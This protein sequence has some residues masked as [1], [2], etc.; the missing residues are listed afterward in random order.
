MKRLRPDYYDRFTCIAGACPITCCQEWKINVDDATARRWKKL[1]PP[2]D[3]EEQ[4]PNLYAYTT[5]K[6]GERVIGLTPDH[7]CPFLNEDK[8]C[9][10]VC[11]HGDQILSRTCQNF[12]REV[13]RFRTHE[14]E[15]LM[16]ACP[17]V[18]DILNE[19][20]TL[21]F[22][23]PLP[24]ELPSEKARLLFRLRAE[25]IRLLTDEARR[26]SSPEEALLSLAY[27]L[28]ELHRTG[29]PDETR[30]TEYFSAASREQLSKALADI[31]LPPLDTL[32]ECNE[33]LQDLAVNYQK[34]GLYPGY[35][36]PVISRAEDLSEGYDA[37][38]LSA[39]WA[40][41]QKAFRAFHPLL[42]RYLENELYSG[43]LLPGNGMDGTGME[44]LLLHLQWIA[45]TYT[46]VRH[47]LFL[48]W[49]LDGSAALP[50][51]TV[52]GYLVILN[53]MTGYNEEDVFEYLENSFEDPLWEWGYF[54]LILGR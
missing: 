17:A 31:Q 29:G 53:R 9:K 51:E 3:V 21:S 32:E 50:Y 47:S 45:L 10:L 6:D 22:P 4:K 33:L 36:N 8:L 13:L 27:I 34:E 7:R 39:Q 42:F 20:Q 30:I 2:A 37:K 11:A 52:R 24:E 46:V 15:T 48:R 40:A 5:R 1:P 38:A 54:A 14:E 25:S 28:L 16:A 18:L 12:P 35:L 44:S 49:L 43:L 19:N 26:G 23:E 41:F